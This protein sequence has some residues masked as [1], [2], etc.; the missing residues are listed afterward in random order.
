MLYASGQHKEKPMV[1]AKLRKSGN[2]FIVTVP[3]EEVNRLQLQEGQLVAVEVHAV[4]LHPVLSP[5]LQAI[6][7][8]FL[9]DPEHLAALRYLA[10]R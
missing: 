7:D 10:D 8:E 5:D 4:E 1:T 9:A 6:I 2:S 3:R